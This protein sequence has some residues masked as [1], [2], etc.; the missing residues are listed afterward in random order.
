M[1]FI[2]K[3]QLV[4]SFLIISLFSFVSISWFHGNEFIGVGDNAISADLSN[5]LGTVNSGWRAEDNTGTKEYY[6]EFY[7]PFSVFLI[8]EKLFNLDPGVGAK[9]RIYLSLFI[10]AILMLIF[11]DLF[12]KDKVHF[13][14]KLSGALFYVFNPYAMLQ[15]LG[16]VMT[17]FPVYL[18]IPIVSYF[19]VKIFDSK[20]T[21]QKFKISVY[22]VFAL[23]LSSGSFRNIAE[24]GPL[25]VISS[26]LIIY[27]L[28]TH[29]KK[30]INI[31]LFVF[32]LLSF[33]LVNFWWLYG[34]L[35]SQYL[36]KDTFIKSVTN[37]DAGGTFIFEAL[38]L[39]GFWALPS[40]F[41]NVLYYPFGKLFYNFWLTL[42]TYSITGLTFLP[43]F[44]LLLPK[45]KKEKHLVSRIKLALILCFVGIFLI[46]GRT[47][48][49]GGWYQYLYSNFP[50]FRIFREPFSKFS[51]IS[52]FSFSVLIS[53]SLSLIIKYVKEKL[54]LYPAFPFIAFCMLMILVSFPMF[55]GQIVNTYTY[56]PIKQSSF[57][58]PEYWRE[59]SRYTRDFPLSGRVLT[60][61]KN[62]YYNKSF[63]WP[64]GVSE[65][66]YMFYLKGSSLWYKDVEPVD[67]SGLIVNDLYNTIEAYTKSKD[68]KHLIK[69]INYSKILNIHYILQMNDFD[70]LSSTG[71]T[72][73][74]GDS[75]SEFYLA[76]EKYGYFKSK[77]QFGYLSRDYLMSIPYVSGGHEMYRFKKDK[78]PETSDFLKAFSGKAALE[79]YTINEAFTTPKIY[80][81]TLSIPYKDPVD[82]SSRAV[83]KD[84]ANE[85]VAYIQ[86]DELESNEGV[87]SPTF[88]KVSDARYALSVRSQ[89]N[90]KVIFNETYDN[91]WAIFSECSLFC[92]K[93]VSAKH[94]KANGY[95]NGWKLDGVDNTSMY[96]ANKAEN[97]L[98]Y[99]SVV[100]FL[101][102]VFLGSLCCFIYAYERIYGKTN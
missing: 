83:L 51:L 80:T 78:D 14:A 77:K 63:I 89:D 79:L 22:L 3:K 87:E 59:L 72:S 54:G 16:V 40:Y 102:L 31:I 53:A 24:L 9:I 69:F 46:K 45:N 84:T 25:A 81:P 41:K 64:S 100:T 29:D 12:F 65:Q 37:F 55:N 56:G 74:S 8:P 96:I 35:Y 11:L 98:M 26:I 1:M 42:A 15:P 19:I 39:F 95:A 38:R 34:S 67:E 73:W 7:L 68:E 90:N 97:R 57:S 88:T 44:Y 18:A 60:M 2:T 28:L 10:P 20:N 32:S 91:E 71:Y 43:I 66:P 5:F 62:G 86:G 76:L 75:L 99:G 101:Y 6:F 47:G 70:W 4:F 17:K 21:Y 85:R 23:T 61:P 33:V 13:L 50:L 52:V 93:E 58:V 48:V 92:T 30:L 49:I 36:M 82:L 27:E 94:F